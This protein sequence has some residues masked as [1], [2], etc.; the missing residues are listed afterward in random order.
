MTRLASVI[1][2]VAEGRI[3]TG[4]TF[5]HTFANE[6]LAT[7]VEEAL[8]RGARERERYE[9]FSSV[10][11]E[12]RTPLTSVRGYIETLLYDEHHEDDRRRL[13]LV[14]RR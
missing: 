13:S 11:H 8:D 5:L 12:L 1:G 6:T 14:D 2:P 9:F 4:W 10:G 7:A 3:A